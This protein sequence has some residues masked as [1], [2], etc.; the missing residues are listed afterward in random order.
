MKL[1]KSLKFKL[2]LGF[3]LEIENQMQLIK[4]RFSI[5]KQGE[6]DFTLLG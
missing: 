6:I 4:C 2:L 1:T 5:V 3:S